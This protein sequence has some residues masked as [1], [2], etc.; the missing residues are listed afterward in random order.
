MECWLGLSGPI[1]RDT[2]ILSLRYPIL[3]KIRASIKIRREES[4]HQSCFQLWKLKCLNRQKNRFGVY[5]KPGFQGKKKENTYTPKRLQGVRGGPLRAVLVYRFWPPKNK[6][7][8][9]PPPQT[10]NTPPPKTRK[11][12]YG[13]GFFLQ[14]ERIFPGVHK[15]DAPISGP[16]IADKNFTDTRMF[17][18]YRAILFIKGIHRAPKMVRYPPPWYLVLHRHIC[19]IPH[20]ATYRAII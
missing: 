17:L 6:I 18:T 4:I 12:F 20:F 2:A 19:L 9:L 1:S 8:T 3:R 10:Q 14:K 13:H 7:G 11:E 5:P 16:R 15:I